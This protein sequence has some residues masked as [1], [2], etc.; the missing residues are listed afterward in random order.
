M[1]WKKLRSASAKNGGNGLR[2]AQ[3]GSERPIEALEGERPGEI[4]EQQQREN[5][6]QFSL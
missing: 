1:A 6:A 5:A 3:R 2:G 4:K